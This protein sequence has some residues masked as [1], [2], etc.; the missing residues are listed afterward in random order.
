MPAYI[1]PATQTVILSQADGI[2]QVSGFNQDLN[3]TGRDGSA[4]L[5]KGDRGSRES[6]NV[7]DD[8]WSK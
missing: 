5:V 2:L 8:D 1:I 3:T 7:W 4:A 6:Y